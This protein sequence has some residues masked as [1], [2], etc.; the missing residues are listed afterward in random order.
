LRSR[1]PIRISRRTRISPS[2]RK[3]CFARQH[4]NNTVENY[5]TRLQKFPTVLVANTFGF[6]AEEFFE[7]AD[8]AAREPVKVSF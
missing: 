6:Q 3:S 8:E 2:F 7:L 4:Y 5:N 1:R